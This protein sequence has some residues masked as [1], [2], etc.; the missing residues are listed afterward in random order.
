MRCITWPGRSGQFFP[1]QALI[2]RPLGLFLTTNLRL[3]DKPW[4]LAIPGMGPWF[5]GAAGTE[6]R[7][8]MRRG[9]RRQRHRGGWG[10]S[11]PLPI[12]LEVWGSI[13]SYPS[14]IWAEL[15]LQLIFFIESVGKQ[16][17]LKAQS[18]CRPL[19]LKVLPPCCRFWPWLYRTTHS[20]QPSTVGPIEWVSAWICI[21][22]DR[23][24]AIYS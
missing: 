19:F 9:S 18:Q 6:S 13:V 4:P 2:Y 8:Q 5:R 20:H 17:N 14:G 15:R 21:A 10:R 7:G 22:H 12:R 1:T 3:Y 23:W 11:I 16:V 24:Y